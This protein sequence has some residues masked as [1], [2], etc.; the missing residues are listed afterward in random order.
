MKITT[1]YSA[2][3]FVAFFA[4]ATVSLKCY[5]GVM[6]NSLKVSGSATDCLGTAYSCVKSV[7][8]TSKI[9]TRNCQYTNCTDA[10]YTTYTAKCTSNG[11]QEIC[12]CY[13][14]GC[15]PASKIPTTYTSPFIIFSI[16]A[17][18]TTYC[19]LH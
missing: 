14:D 4:S 2:V 10:G 8:L 9:A 7:D 3:A 19:I 12:C 18:L 5:Q 15:N 16:F 13:G 11:L 17:F 1:S 6:N